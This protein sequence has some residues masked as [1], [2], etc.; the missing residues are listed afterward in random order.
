MLGPV[1][2][3]FPGLIFPAPPPPSDRCCHILRTGCNNFPCGTQL[4]LDKF[5]PRAMAR[6]I[7]E[8]LLARTRLFFFPELLGQWPEPVGIVLICLPAKPEGG[9]GL[10]AY[11][12][13]SLG[14]G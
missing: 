3:R 4:G 9:E 1:S 6:L 7:D 13:Q 5:H 11:F 14:C 2:P 12:L 8:A 10:L